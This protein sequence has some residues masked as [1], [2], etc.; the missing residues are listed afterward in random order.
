MHIE[1][2]HSDTGFCNSQP[3]T[4]CLKQM[5]YS[6]VNCTSPR[7][8]ITDIHNE[9]K[10]SDENPHVD[11]ISPMAMTVFHQPMGWYFR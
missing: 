8:E 1:D 2:T 5:F 3:K 6:Q 10:W 4:L 9:H 7:T 11:S